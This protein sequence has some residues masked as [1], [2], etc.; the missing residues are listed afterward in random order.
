MLEG[1]A[2]LFLEPP[3]LTKMAVPAFGESP[4]Y[5]T[6][7]SSS[8]NASLLEY[9]FAHVLRSRRVVRWAALL[10]IA[11]VL[12]IVEFLPVYVPSVAS[13]ARWGCRTTMASLAVAGKRR[14]FALRR[15]H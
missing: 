3:M 8:I 9:S 5:R 6:S 4:T 14:P 15:E 7:P 10:R 13:S 12:A 11:L 1:A 2:L